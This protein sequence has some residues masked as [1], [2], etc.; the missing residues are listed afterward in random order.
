M[1]LKKNKTYFRNLFFMLVFFVPVVL[2]GQKLSGRWEGSVEQEGSRDVYYYTLEITV[3][4]KAVSGYAT[5]KSE[6]GKTS[7]EFLIT[8]IAEGAR[9]LLQEIKQLKPEQPQWCLKSIILDYTE[10]DAGS[11]LAGNWT[12]KGCKPGTM[13]LK[14]TATIERDIEEEAF[15]MTGKWTGN[16]SQSDRDYGFY[17]ELELEKA[18]VGTSMI[19]SEGNG[20]S[21]SHALIWWYDE[22][23]E[24]VT[25][26]EDY[27]IE[28]TDE[29]WKWCIKS[30]S[31]KLRRQGMSYFI[32][33]DWAGFIEGKDPELGACAS[34]SLVLEKPVLTR[35]IKR[36]ISVL[37]KPYE[38]Q[39]DRIV[40]VGRTV[41]VNSK[42][43]KIKIWDSGTVDGDYATLFL[44]GERIL[45]NY[46]VQKYK[47]GIPVVLNAEE[48]LLILHAEDLG[49]IPP[50]TVAVSV[51]DGAKETVI[52]M[53]SNLKESDAILIRR[54]RLKD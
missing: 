52:I 41:E 12:A 34:G 42:N 11:E 9:L 50:N 35:E 20:G 8:G 1:A 30:G 28:R 29:N 46:R 48:N 31:F 14:K 21:A 10:L 40:K 27:V 32:E 44:N 13:V 19:V 36:E 37:T 43:V 4:E 47:K 23:T 26:K 51:V 5:S 2:V 45:N 22:N 24:M 53:N 18:G 17:Y 39:T 16:L 38:E 25:I 7:A 54:F 33:G 49:D 3:E 15:V 6:D